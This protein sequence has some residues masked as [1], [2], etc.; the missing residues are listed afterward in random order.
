MGPLALE[1]GLDATDGSSNGTGE[2]G[3]MKERKGSDPGTSVDQRFSPQL[4]E[5]QCSNCDDNK[6]NEIC[7][8]IS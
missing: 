2:D 4:S 6:T 5:T 8:A 7:D 1:I 3:G